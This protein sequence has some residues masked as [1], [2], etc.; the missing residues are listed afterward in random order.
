M[1]QLISL[2]TIGKDKSNNLLTDDF[3]KNTLHFTSQA[4]ADAFEIC[5]YSR[6]TVI[7]NVHI[8]ENSN[9]PIN[10]VFVAP[11]VTPV[12]GVLEKETN[13]PGVRLFQYKPGD[14]TLLVRWDSR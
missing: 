6:K 11:A 4:F 13:N 2:Q 7:G 14:Y 3:V 1:G 8:N 5:N 9:N 12:K 10:S